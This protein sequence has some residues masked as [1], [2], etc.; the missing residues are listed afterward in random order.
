MT[1]RIRPRLGGCRDTRL[2]ERGFALLIVL[3]TLVL[4]TLV[5]TEVTASARSEA[6]QAFNLRRN[7]EAEASAD[8]A[9]FEAV[10]HLADA[11]DQHWAPDGSTH[12]WRLGRFAAA[13]RIDDERW[14]INPNTASVEMLQALL[15]AVGVDA[16]NA[17][18]L[19]AAIIDWRT[20][21][22]RPH[23]LGAREP[24][25]RAAGRDYAPPG[26]PMSGLAELGLVLGMTPDLLARL[27]PHLSLYQ[28]GD[29]D[30]TTADP[31]VA[32]VLA[33]LGPD[34]TMPSDS[35]D[36][37]LIAAITASVAGPD[38]TRFTR[39]AVVRVA[40]GQERPWQVLTWD[41]PPT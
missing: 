27:A 36:G 3:W 26:A 16:R 34:A 35:G 39:R 12:R 24:E 7:A 22:N 1:A 38:G 28:D 4:L 2:G 41:A 8:A 19:A 32:G 13:V 17:A 31:V 14:K 9:L 11:A 37:S 23:K 40:M 30:R 15:Q 6:Q 5:V 20:P 21:G 25:Y 33:E 18:G 10:F 29:P